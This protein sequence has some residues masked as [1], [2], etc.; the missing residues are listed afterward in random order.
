MD[1]QTTRDKLIQS[2]VDLF[3]KK[4]Y[5]DVSVADICRQ[6]EL[7]NGVFYRYFRNK[8]EIFKCLVEEFLLLMGK[9][10][11]TIHGET[12]EEKLEQFILTI[13]TL[14]KHHY[15]RLN[16]FREGQYRFHEYEKR[17]QQIYHTTVEQIYERPMTASEYFY[18]LSGLR[19]IAYRSQAHNVPVSSDTIKDIIL[20]GVFINPIKD[21]EKIF[22]RE[23]TPLNLST[24]ETTVEKLIK[25]GR[26]LFGN[27]DYFYV[28][29]DEITNTSQ[30]AIGTFYKYF[31]SKLTF[32]CEVID[33]ID[34]DMRRF[35]NKNLDNSL[36]QLEQEIQGMFLYYLFLTI[37][38]GCYNI[39]REA[40]FV[41]NDRAQEY[42]NLFAQSDFKNL[43]GIKQKDI[44][45]VNNFLIGIT[46][47]LSIEILLNMKSTKNVK[48]FLIE[49]SNH[50]MNGISS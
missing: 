29:I 24:E 38:K 11:D 21:Y 15:K 47:Y 9:A 19:F 23:V 10:L 16:I 46:H 28:H 35:I 45:T 32:F 20:H 39:V 3:S 12:I 22:N 7:S 6:A 17:L 50:L 43:S 25:S 14:T 18:I 37:D 36:N 30:L 44:P 41:I 27:K 26:R 49:L 42:Y 31:D 5:S 8:E 40:E 33:Q 34:H 1:N 48:D 13:L 2:A 4:R